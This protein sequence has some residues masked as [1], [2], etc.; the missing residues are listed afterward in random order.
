M[1]APEQ[2]SAPSLVSLRC[3]HTHTH[4]HSR[5]GLASS[6]QFH[7]LL[8]AACPPDCAHPPRP[9][10]PSRPC[11]PAA[12]ARAGR[13]TPTSSSSP[14]WTAYMRRA[15]RGW[16]PSPP[17]TSPT[18]PLSTASSG[19]ACAARCVSGGCG[20]GPEVRGPGRAAV[21]RASRARPHRTLFMLSYIT[22]A[23]GP[24]CAQ[25]KCAECGYESNTYDPCIDLSLEITRA[26]S[27]LKALERFTAGAGGG[28]GRQAHGWVDG[29]SGSSPAAACSRLVGASFPHQCFASLTRLHAPPTALTRPWTCT[30]TCTAHHTPQARCWTAPTST[31]APSRAR[32][33][34]R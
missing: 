7:D 5:A 10:A 16:P 18:P 12:S 8:C 6:I 29:E 34:R 14:C 13:R 11:L 21:G 26:Q 19:G 25:I 32:R 20:D 27:V 2:H 28:G 33:C 1:H 4:T 24:L 3:T 22:L 23:L 31:S 15:S 30:C 17:P 9:P